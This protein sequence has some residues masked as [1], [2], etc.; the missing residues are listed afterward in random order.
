PIGTEVRE[1]LKI[2][3]AKVILH[4]DIYVT[5]S[6]GNCKK[7]D[8]AVPVV[9]T[10]KESALI[11][12]SCASAEAVAHIAVQKYVMGSP[13]YRQ[14]QEWNRQGVMLSRQ[15]MSNWLLRSADDWLAPI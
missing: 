6:C 3:P 10:P 5:Y 1:T 13:L 2:I 9:E 4:R 11:S 12:G 8:I 7:N 15:T 14:E